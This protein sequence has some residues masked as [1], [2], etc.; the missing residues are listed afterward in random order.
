MSAACLLVAGCYGSVSLYGG[1][2]DAVGDTGWDPGMETTHDPDA[3]P[4][5]DPDADPF[6]DTPDSYCDPCGDEIPDVPCWSATADAGGVCS[7]I[8]QCGCPPG[9]WCTW[10]LSAACRLFEDCYAGDAGT[11]DVGEEC[12]G[13]ATAVECR[14]GTD[15]LPNGSTSLC[16]EWCTDDADCSLAGT[17]CNV[18]VSFTLPPPCAGVGVATPPYMVCSTV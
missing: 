11:H 13:H 10:N 5:V 9:A 4:P 6:V 1:D 16:Y 3:D 15:C 14:P 7:V 2:G 18:P 8:D 12:S 17:E